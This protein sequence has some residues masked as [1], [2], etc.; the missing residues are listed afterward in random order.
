MEEEEEKG[1]R[2]MDVLEEM[3]YGYG[4]ALRLTRSPG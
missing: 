1:I 2:D 3:A 4:N